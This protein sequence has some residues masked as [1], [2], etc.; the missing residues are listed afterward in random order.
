M[1][2]SELVLALAVAFAL[3]WTFNLIRMNRAEREVKA[4]NGW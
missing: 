3:V 4:R 2:T 1:G